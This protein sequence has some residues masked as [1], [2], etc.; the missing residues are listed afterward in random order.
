MNYGYGRTV[1]N[2]IANSAN[3]NTA[4]TIE[5]NILKKGEIVSEH[6][7]IP[8]NVTEI[9]AGA[10]A[11]SK[12]KEKLKELTIS[13][14]VKKIG[15]R[16]F[17]G[18]TNLAVIHFDSWGASL[19]QV[20]I[21]AFSG[22][23]WLKKAQENQIF[24]EL[25][26][27]L[28]SAYHD[29]FTIEARL[30]EENEYFDEDENKT[31]RYWSSQWDNIAS[32]AFYQN[33]VKKVFVPD[34]S[35]IDKYAF[36][37]S[38]IERICF[39]CDFFSNNP[40]ISKCTKLTQIY[41]TENVEKIGANFLEE[42]P[43]LKTVFLGSPEIT[44]HKSAFPPNVEFIVVENEQLFKLF[45]S[46]T[47]KYIIGDPE[48]SEQINTT[49]QSNSKNLD[50]IDWDNFLDKMKAHLSKQTD[51]TSNNTHIE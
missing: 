12:Q 26:N 3:G 40:V 14:H 4:L 15:E 16:A 11:F 31:V 24:V 27:T 33:D 41:L 38:G 25:G 42:C 47:N 7:I 21:E 45:N 1:N 30:G 35:F 39:D 51:A 34:I 10:F 43:N 44:I 18:L 13:K 37:E 9:A 20:G 28:I 49:G 22:T 29:C 6:I 8:D 36:C 2:S 50:D 46:N 23:A 19:Q 5:N 32:H 48:P 17:Y